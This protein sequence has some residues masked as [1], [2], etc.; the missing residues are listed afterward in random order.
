MDTTTS[1]S[2]P[3]EAYVSCDEAGVIYVKP[4]DPLITPYRLV[5]VYSEGKASIAKFDIYED[6]V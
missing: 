3:H 5:L 2:V 4:T 1:I 6:S